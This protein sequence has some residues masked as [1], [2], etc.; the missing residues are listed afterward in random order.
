[1]CSSWNET[2]R[3]ISAKDELIRVQVKPKQ[4]E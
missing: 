3:P 2:I 1:V 4:L